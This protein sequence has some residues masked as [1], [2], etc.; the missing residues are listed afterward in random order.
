MIRVTEFT[1]RQRLKQ[2]DDDLLDVLT[3]LNSTLDT[4]ETLQQEYL[5]D[6]LQQALGHKNTSISTGDAIMV[7]LQ[8]R[9]KEVH[10]YLAKTENLRAKVAGTTE[11]VCEEAFMDGKQLTSDSCPISLTLAMVTL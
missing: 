1:E 7:G 10:L 3:V 11:L 8:Q 2:I 9:E 5:R 4:I 6:D